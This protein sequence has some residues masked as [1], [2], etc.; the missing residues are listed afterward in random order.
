MST[1]SRVL[2]LKK[3]HGIMD[4]NRNVAVFFVGQ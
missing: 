2:V 3:F 1:S 4:G